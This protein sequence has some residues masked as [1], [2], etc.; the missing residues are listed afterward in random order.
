MTLYLNLMN[1]VNSYLV[2]TQIFIWILS[3]YKKLSKK[4][5][6]IIEN[7]DNTLFLSSISYWEIAIKTSLGKLDIP[8]LLENLEQEAKSRNIITLNVT[9]KHFLQVAKLPFHH[10]DPFDRVIIS[11]AILENTPLISSD[12]KFK[13]YQELEY[14]W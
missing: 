2:D 7:A 13:L 10:N 5:L 1:T 3:D 9:N 6:E 14:I 12:G 11:Q 8:I 4:A